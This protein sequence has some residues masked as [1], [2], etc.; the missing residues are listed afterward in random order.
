MN[1]QPKTTYVVG[2]LLGTTFDT[3]VLIRKARPLWQRGYFNGIGGH[4]E[5]GEE[6]IDA[7]RREFQEETGL[8]IPDWQHYCNLTAPGY[9]QGGVAE[10]HFFTANC[11]GLV[12]LHK[13]TDEPVEWISRHRLH[14][15]KV[16]P[17]LHWLI[18]MAYIGPKGL[19]GPNWPYK[20][21]ESMC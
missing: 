10:V 5:S 14:Q 7:M 9:E 4:V 6:P 21:T 8:V 11:P 13:T 3:V 12:T 18:P 16:I 1:E 19:R 17:N 2:F 20:V 15:Y